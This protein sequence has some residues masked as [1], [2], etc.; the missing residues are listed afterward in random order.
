MSIPAAL[1]LG[2]WNTARTLT[3]YGDAHAGETAKAAVGMGV[4]GL[5][6]Q[7]LVLVPLLYIGWIGLVLDVVLTAV[8]VPSLARQRVLSKLDE[9]RAAER[10]RRGSQS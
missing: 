6:V 1:A 3:A 9:A 10:L 5:V 2:P 8:L 4:L 7:A